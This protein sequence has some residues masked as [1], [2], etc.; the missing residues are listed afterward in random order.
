MKY[1]INTTWGGFSVPTEVCERLKCDPYCFNVDEFDVRAS[2][3]L[4]A[5]VEAHPDGD[6]GVVNIPDN[7]TDWEINE[8][9]GL[10]HIIAVVDGKIVHRYAER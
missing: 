7:A 6:L 2:S 9:D 5:W 8:Y 10:E 3:E 1:V 4:I